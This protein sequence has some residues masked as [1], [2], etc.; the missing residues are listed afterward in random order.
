MSQ[1]WMN[2]PRSL[3]G[4]KALEVGSTDNSMPSILPMWTKPVKKITVSG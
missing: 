1:K 4:K 2:Q 3:V